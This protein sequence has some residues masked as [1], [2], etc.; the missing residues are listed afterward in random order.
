MTKFDFPSESNE[1]RHAR[2]ELLAAEIALKNEVERVAAM[3]RALPLGMP[4]PEYVFREGPMDL[5][6]NDPT[7][8][9]DVR[10]T[11]L[12]ADGHDTLIV[13]HLMFGAGDDAPC[14]MC[15]MWADGYNAIAPHIMRRASFVLVA[16]AEIGVLRRWA[17]QRGWDRIRLL[18]SHD[19][20]FNR[21]FGMESEN[22]DQQPGLSVFSRTPDGTV[23]HRYSVGAEL[24]AGE[25]PARTG[26]ASTSTRPPGNC[27]T[28]RRT[29]A[30]TGI[31]ATNTWSAAYLHRSR[32]FHSA[33]RCRMTSSAQSPS[34]H[35]QR[36]GDDA[37]STRVR[38]RRH[39]EREGCC[40]GSRADG[41]ARA[42]RRMPG[43]SRSGR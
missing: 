42:R 8:F 17:R 43:S 16:K 30:V 29:G 39:D 19:S 36:E 3:R 9:S 23:S 13:D 27:L 2:A 18:S 34:S 10:L 24:G 14:V 20:T 41:D 12:F 22:G 11:D 37:T 35:T 26:A 21:D 32:E 6:R 38:L 5:S 31:R 28:S 15:S 4:V 7:D 1:Y 25:L 40:N 33:R